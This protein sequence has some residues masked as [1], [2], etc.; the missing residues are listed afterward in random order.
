MPVMSNEDGGPCRPEPDKAVGFEWW[1]PGPG[2]LT[3]VAASISINK[4]VN[5]IQHEASSLPLINAHRRDSP[6]LIGFKT[7]GTDTGGFSSAPR[8]ELTLPTGTSPMGP[9][10]MDWR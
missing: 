4:S 7:L 9:S 10:R 6:G 5:L 8:D 1:V 2:R 3:L